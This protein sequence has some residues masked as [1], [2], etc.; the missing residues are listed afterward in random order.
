[1]CVCVCVWGGGGGGGD[2]ES[3]LK[4]ETIEKI[5]KTSLSERKKIF[6]IRKCVLQCNLCRKYLII[7]LDYIH[8]NHRI[9]TMNRS[10]RLYSRQSS[11]KDNEQK[12]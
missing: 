4:E 3:N 2:I 9:K 1:M 11:Y 6:R 10:R 5:L 8:V 12:L 7:A